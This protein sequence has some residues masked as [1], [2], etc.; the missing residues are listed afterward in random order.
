[1]SWQLW[2][3][4]AEPAAWQRQTERFAAHCREQGVRC[5]SARVA[6]AHHFSIFDALSEP[7]GAIAGALIDA[8]HSA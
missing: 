8:L 1:V 4:D 7:G 6:G 2:T 3:G 5:R